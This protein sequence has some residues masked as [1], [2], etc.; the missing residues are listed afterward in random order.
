[1]IFLCVEGRFLLS[2]EQRF[3]NICFVIFSLTCFFF[4]TFIHTPSTSGFL[5]TLPKH[6]HC[7]APADSAWDYRRGG[8]LGGTGFHCL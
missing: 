8:E 7:S 3:N 4:K 6:C 2:D 1:M 5:P